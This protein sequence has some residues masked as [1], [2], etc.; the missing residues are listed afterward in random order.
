MTIAACAEATEAAETEET[1]AT[2]AADR[3]EATEAADA[4]RTE[5]TEAAEFAAPAAALQASDRQMV[6]PMINSEREKETKISERRKH[7]KQT[8]RTVTV[9]CRV[10]RQKL[11]SSFANL[12]ANGPA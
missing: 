12:L 5:E 9:Q 1:L 10:E 4:A 8:R 7:S 3:A 6:W 11:R 2:E